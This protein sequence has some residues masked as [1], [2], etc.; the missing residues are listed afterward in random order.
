MAATCSGHERGTVSPF[1][2]AKLQDCGDM[3]PRVQPKP[4]KLPALLQVASLAPAGVLLKPGQAKRTRRSVFCSGV[5]A[6]PAESSCP[7]SGNQ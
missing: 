1:Q 7:R 3:N 5:K 4:W 2:Q 6:R